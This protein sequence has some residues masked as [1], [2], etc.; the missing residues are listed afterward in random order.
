MAIDL[1]RCRVL[2]LSQDWDIHTPG[3][4][5]Y[6]GPTVKWIK[7]VAFER[8]GGQWISS[9]LHVGTHLDAPL[10]FITGGQ[11]IAAIPLNKL[12]GWGLHRRSHP[13]RDRRLR[14]LRS[15]ALRAVGTRYRH[16]HRAGGHSR[17]PYRVPSLLSER[18]GDGSS[19]AA[20]GRDP[21]LHQASGPDPRVRRL[22]PSATDLVARG[23]LCLGR[24]PVQHGDPKDSRRPRA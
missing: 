20:A 16:P 11:D 12:V 23:R 5:L 10:H 17:H 15:R 8:A 7:R 14:Y 4:A 22:G 13:L 2:D 18:L 1:A 9:T 21:L 6:E 24:S 19:A 3:F